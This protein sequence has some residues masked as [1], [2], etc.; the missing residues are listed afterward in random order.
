MKKWAIKAIIGSGILLG[1]A[2]TV[3]ASDLIYFDR[4]DTYGTV[5]YI[6]TEKGGWTSR[7]YM[8]IETGGSLGY[9]KWR[10]VELVKNTMGVTCDGDLHL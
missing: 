4:C 1:V 7:G 8:S 2:G 6:Q 5:E 10:G 3:F 9:K